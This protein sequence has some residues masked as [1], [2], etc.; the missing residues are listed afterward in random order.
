VNDF[1]TVKNLTKRF[2]GLCALSNLSFRVDEEELFGIIGPNG[3][4]KTTLFNVI[5]GVY[6]ADSGEIIFC[7]KNLIGQPP[8]KICRLGIART[9][10]IPRPF[11]NLTV[12]E[13]LLVA[14]LSALNMEYKDAVTYN[15]EV[16]KL[17]ELDKLKDAYAKTLMPFQLKKLEVARALACKPKLLLLDEPAA[18]ARGEEVE[19]FIK[20]INR[21]HSMGVTII[22]VEHR[23]E[24]VTKVAKRILVMHQGAKLFEGEP[25]KVLDSK[26]VIDAYL[27]EE[28][29]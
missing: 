8:Y 7:G 5:S 13:N 12:L 22:L 10:Q 20:V 15:L 9:F 27:G 17:L 18:G 25:E 24:V 28:R 1:L 3:S 16:L 29:E 11:P 4:G 26:I 23:M 6:G 21:I 2:G 19:N 14:S